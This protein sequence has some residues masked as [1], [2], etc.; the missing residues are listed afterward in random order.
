MEVFSLSISIVHFTGLVK[1][2]Q[3]FEWSISSFPEKA[4]VIFGVV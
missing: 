4:F 1:K 2:F 3:G